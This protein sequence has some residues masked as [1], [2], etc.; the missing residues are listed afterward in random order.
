MWGRGK[1]GRGGGKTGQGLGKRGPGMRERC[2]WHWNMAGL[3]E[4]T[5]K[6]QACVKQVVWQVGM[7]SAV[8]PAAV[9]SSY[10]HSQ[11]I[12]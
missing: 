5:A 3:S 1:G 8:Q 6:E 4:G 10:N 2:R 7:T 11:G 9:L 12:I